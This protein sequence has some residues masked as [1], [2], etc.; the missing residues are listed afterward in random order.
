MKKIIWLII[1]VIVMNSKLLGQVTAEDYYVYRDKDFSPK[2]SYDM[3]EAKAIKGDI[4]SMVQ[5]FALLHEFP[6]TLEDEAE[7][8]IGFLLEAAKA[9]DHMAQYNLGL[10]SSTGFFVAKDLENANAWLRSA[11]EN[12]SADANVLLG[13]NLYVM[14]VSDPK[15]PK[16]SEQTFALIER[17]LKYAE[18]LN[19]V[20]GMATLA[21][22]Y[23]LEKSDFVNARR[24]LKHAIGLGD[25]ESQNTLQIFQKQYDYENELRQ[26]L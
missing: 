4:D 24:L 12:G 10:I 9:D 18:D 17:H 5:T 19:D 11:I 6:Q 25:E 3:F 22:L 8:A 13:V 21:R 15:S 7:Q 16:L 14:H 2:K 20:V 26:E 1:L 23:F